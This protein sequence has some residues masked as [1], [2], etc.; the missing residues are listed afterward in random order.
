MKLNIT[1]SFSL[2]SLSIATLFVGCNGFEDED[3]FDKPASIRL[4]ENRTEVQKTL[5]SSEQGWLLQYFP[6]PDQIYGGVNYFLK[7]KDGNVTVESFSGKKAETS[8]YSVISRGGSVIT[9]D[10]YNSLLH[11]YANPS[12]DLP[13]GKQGDFEFLVLNLTDNILDLKGLRSGNKIRL[14]KLENLDEV[15]TKIGIIRSK[16]EKI[17]FPAKGTINGKELSVSS[18]NER[19]LVFDYEGADKSKTQKNPYIYTENG[20]QFYTPF[21][22]N[23]KKYS[24]LIYDQQ[25]KVLKSEDG[26]IDIK[27]SFIP[28]DFKNKLFLLNLGDNKYSSRTFRMA[29]SFDDFYVPYNIYEK[30][31][32]RDFYYLGKFRNKPSFSTFV[33]DRSTKR[34][35]LMASQGLKFEVDESDDDAINIVKGDPLV[36]GWFFDSV[37]NVLNEVVKNAPYVVSK[38]ED[39]ES[40]KYKLTSKKDSEVWFYLDEL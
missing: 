24:N 5:E 11:S 6:H 26:V 7:F 38:E 18:P 40:V 14:I 1:K 32:L 17:D 22:V 12:R 30:Y 36:N 34:T 21:E 20:I 16:L 25:A 2:V 8:G 28:I 9:F 35:I 33:R 15:K 31:E 39:G 3:L 10:Q 37:N 29:H 13:K 23:G 19:N 4:E 27:L